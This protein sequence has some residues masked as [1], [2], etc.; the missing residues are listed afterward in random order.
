[1]RVAERSR[2]GVVRR[3]LLEMLIDLR[4]GV[5]GELR[6]GGVAVDVYR[7]NLQRAYLEAFD[8]QLNPAD[9]P[10]TGTGPAVAAQRRQ[11]EELRAALMSDVRPLLRELDRQAAAAVGRSGDPMTRLHLQD[12]RAEIARILDPRR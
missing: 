6:S 11:Q 4:Q 7:R 1:V 10:I 9:Q 5:W 8:R 2:R 12:V 3:P